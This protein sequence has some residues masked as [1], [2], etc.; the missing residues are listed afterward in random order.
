MATVIKQGL[1]PDP[2]WLTLRAIPWSVFMSER[3]ELEYTVQVLDRGLKGQV[4]RS[5]RVVQPSV[6]RL[7]PHEKLDEIIPGRSVSNVARHG[8]SL[9]FTLTGEP[10]LEMLV[11]PGLTG[12][13][14]LDAPDKPAPGDL[15]VAFVLADGRELR[16]RDDNQQGK[17][18]LM[19]PGLRNRVP[20]MSSLGLDVLDPK[21]FSRAAFR[22]LVRR[23]RD[24]AKIFLMDMKA[25]DLI[26]NVYADEVLFDAGIH[27]TT[28]ISE[29]RDDRVD[30]LHD[31]A[32]SVLTWARDEI[33]KRKPPIDEKIRDFLRV[34]NRFGQPCQRCSTKIR[35]TSIRGQDAFFCPTCQPLEPA[36]PRTNKP[37][38]LD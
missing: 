20:G 30:T 38:F 3:P 31:S 35:I 5:V 18:F 22:A 37:V 11:L 25:L 10:A 34:R 9:V 29:L 24:P 33:S 28:R 26:G 12:R 23:R 32:V 27:P 4:F 17:I 15:A 21:S 19:A 36:G 2:A 13:F 7:L 16:Y 6:P 14:G 1:E 8:P